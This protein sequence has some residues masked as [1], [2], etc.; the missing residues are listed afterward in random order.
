MKSI[1]G[2]EENTMDKG[3]IDSFFKEDK[4]NIQ[5]CIMFN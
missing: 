5:T 1:L 2:N 4:G 3:A